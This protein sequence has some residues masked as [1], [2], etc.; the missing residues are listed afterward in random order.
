[1][2]NDPLVS[3]VIGVRNMEETIGTTIESIL[4]Q[5]YPNK[6]IIVINDGSDDNTEEII[7]KYP[8]R[9]INTNKLGIS[10]ARNL[11][12]RNSNGDYVAFTDADCELDP[13]WTEIILQKFNDK[14]IGLIGGRTVFKTNDS[15]TSKYRNIE[16][17]KRYKNIAN[18]DGFW[19]GG[20]GS[21]FK[22]E[23]LNEI[24]GF[25]PNWVHGEDSEIS[26]LIIEHGYK[27][28]N[29][30]NAI[31]Y[32][33]PE[34]GFWRLIRKGYRDAKAHVR[35]SKSHRKTYF[36]GKFLTTWYFKYDLITL[37]IL[38]AFMVLS[39]IFLTILYLLDLFF[40]L[41]FLNYF[42]LKII[43]YIWLWVV[44]F[45]G[46]FLITYGFIPS[47]HVASLSENKKIRAFIGTTLLHNIRGFAWGIGLIIG[48]KN[49]VI[50]K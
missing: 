42:F 44:F 38:Y 11:G 23:I 1:M 14:K 26:L 43:W 34:S 31:T 25:N 36:Q 48:I 29:E 18:Q 10:N 41:S 6:E 17:T 5:T 9:I 12:Y 45:I 4:N 35:V 13:R 30:S 22:K 15:Y 32:H 21:M 2:T 40:Y 28:Y 16:F 7:K 49:I 37:P 20:P 46:I 24:G 27:V 19:A 3:F 50:K 33:T 47:Y 39:G 8:V